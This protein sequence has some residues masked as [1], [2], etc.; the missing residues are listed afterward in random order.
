MSESVKVDSDLLDRI[1]EAVETLASD[2]AGDRAA[3]HHELE[4]CGLQKLAELILSYRELARAWSC[5]LH[6]A[7]DVL[8]P[9]CGLC[10]NRVLDGSLYYQRPGHCIVCSDCIEDVLR[11]E[12]GWD[13][14]KN[15]TLQWLA[16][17]GIE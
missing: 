2:R 9:Q 6:L 7:E 14:V 17:L 8:I 5:K 3:A 10:D 1:R 4:R 11:V 16:N 15:R 13:P 12:A